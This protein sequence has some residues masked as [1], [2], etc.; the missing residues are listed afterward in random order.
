MRRRSRSVQLG[1]FPQELGGPCQYGVVEMDRAGFFNRGACTNSGK[2]SL[3]HA[4]RHTRHS[5]VWLY[6]GA[7]RRL[8]QATWKLG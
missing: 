1:C 8:S 4:A 6:P 3:S 7:W 5:L 2:I